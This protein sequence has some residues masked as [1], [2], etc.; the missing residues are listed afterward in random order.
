MGKVMQLLFALIS[1]GNINHNLM[2][3]SVAAN[4]ASSSADLLTDLKSGYLLGANPRKQFLAQF[5]GVFS[6]TL[7]ATYGYSVLVP[8]PEA[9]GGDKFAAPSAQVWRAVAEVLA[10]GFASLPRYAVAAMVVGAALGVGLTLLEKTLPA[11]AA[12]WVPSPI[13]FGMAFTFQG[14]T[15]MAFFLG[16]LAAWLYE[17]RRPEAAGIYTIPVA[18]GFIAG[19]TLMGV[20]IAFMMAWGWL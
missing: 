17:K 2:S 7:V 19:E 14:Y 18:S 11:R 13:G 5:L 20:A 10:R 8:R 15:A 9:I 12:R 1:K 16:G 3:A 6:G 4:S